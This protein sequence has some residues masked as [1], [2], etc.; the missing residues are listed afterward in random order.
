MPARQMIA[1][2]SS[3]INRVAHMH[4]ERVSAVWRRCTRGPCAQEN[5]HIF[6]FAKCLLL[7]EQKKGNTF[8]QINVSRWITFGSLLP[9]KIEYVRASFSLFLNFYLMSAA[10][11]FSCAK[12]TIHTKFLTACFNT[13]LKFVYC[14]T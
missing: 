5:G 10:E 4:Q 7:H 13:S 2:M 1:K 9:V 3:P 8:D 11:D 12:F 14:C 6:R